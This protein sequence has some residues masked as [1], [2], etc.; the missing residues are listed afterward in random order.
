MLA[1]SKTSLKNFPGTMWA[2]RRKICEHL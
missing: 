1:A 2:R